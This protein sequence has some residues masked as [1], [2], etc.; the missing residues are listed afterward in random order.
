MSHQGRT[1]AQLVQ[2]SLVRICTGYAVTLPGVDELPPPRIA[3][4]APLVHQT[5]QERG[6]SPRLDTGRF[7]MF[8]ALKFVAAGVIVALFGGFLLAGVLTTQQDGEVLPAA[9]TESPRPEVTAAPTEPT[10]PSDSS[11]RSDIL[12]GVTLTVEEVEPGVF[13]VINDG[14]R[15][16]NKTYGSVNVGYDG[17]IWLFGQSGLLRLGSHETHAWP[18]YG[19]PGSAFEVVR[20][21]TM[22]V[23]RGMYDHFA[24]ASEGRRSTDG[25]EWTVQTCPQGR[26]CRAFT[27]APDGTAWATWRDD[28]GRWRVGHLG[29]SGWQPLD[30]T[31]RGTGTMKGYRRLFVTDTGDIYGTEKLGNPLFHHEDGDWEWFAEGYGHIDAGHDGT[32]WHDGNDGLNRF[33]D[34]EWTRWTSADLPAI[35][36]GF[37]LDRDPWPWLYEHEFSVAPDGSLWFSLWQKGAKG[38]GGHDCDGLARFD[39]ATFDRFL[40]GRCTKSMDIAPDGSV[41]LRA[42]DADLELVRSFDLYVITPEAVS[43]AEWARGPH[44]RRLTQSTLSVSWSDSR[45]HTRCGDGHTHVVGPTPLPD[46]TLAAA[47]QPQVR[48]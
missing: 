14:V 44:D 30:G 31:P 4:I 6:L 27:V 11:V 25:E 28:I 18:E 22:W 40:R 42:H 8:S 33:A 39:G 47:T 37:V 15:D 9:V 45:S 2:A 3:E 34:G 19:S 13:R 46:L 29:P 32:L 1:L 17:S 35:R 23:I 26:S 5:P 43:A 12:P 38:V 20:D 24:G 21:G 7:H 16:M 36:H 10:E 41:W 48:G